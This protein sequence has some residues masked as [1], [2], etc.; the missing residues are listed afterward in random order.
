MFYLWTIFA[1]CCC[2]D[3]SLDDGRLRRGLNNEINLFL[4]KEIFYFGD[5]DLDRGRYSR[6]CWT[7]LRDRE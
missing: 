4:F 1:A 5:D 6:L 2:G 7:G 3:R